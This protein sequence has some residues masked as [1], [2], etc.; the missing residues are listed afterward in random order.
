LLAPR[1]VLGIRGR[2]ERSTVHPE[3][4]ETVEKAWATLGVSQNFNLEVRPGGHQ[5]FVEPAIVFFRRHL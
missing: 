5:Y 2:D 4:L 3:F 1:P